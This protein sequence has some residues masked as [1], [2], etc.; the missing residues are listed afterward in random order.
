V[1]PAL[2]TLLAI[3]CL[4]VLLMI[5]V[6]GP[7]VFGLPRQFI[8][9]FGIYL[10]DN[11]AITLTNH[12][13]QLQVLPNHVW[14]GFL[15]WGW[16]GKTYSIVL[17]L[18]L[19]F[20]SR[21]L[22]APRTAGL[23][24]RQRP[25]SAVPAVM[26]LVLITAGMSAWGSTFPKGQF[27]SGL[28]L[29]LAV[30]PGVNEELVYRGVLPACLEGRFATIW[31]VASAP[32]SWGSLLATLLFALL[33]GLWFDGQFTFHVDLSLIRNALIAGL[34]FAWLRARTGSLLMPIL[35][36]GAWD[37]FFFLPRML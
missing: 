10:A 1:S 5:A 30:L 29:Y 28:L 23:T 25:G 3:G 24:L 15:L 35:A 11:L 22:V 36:H 14:G 9:F 37:L 13:P 6:G 34:L 8:L 2:A 31:T 7:A 33:H 27:D 32:L 19:S 4:E 20:F 16:S 26:L 17:V 21:L 12:L 18:V